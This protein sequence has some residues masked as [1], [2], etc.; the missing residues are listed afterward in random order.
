MSSPPDR[1]RWWVLLA[2]TGS[3]S[4]IMID[5]TIITVALP[6]IH[7]DLGIGQGMLEWVVI[8]YILVLASMMALG[9]HV[10]DIIGKPKAFVIG[11][12]AFGV[13]SLLCGM[14]WDGRSL[15]FFR[16]LQGL[17]AV[18]MQPASSALVIGSFAPGERGKAMG[19]YAGISLL[20]LTIGPV[21]GGVITEFASWRYCFYINLPVSLLVAAGALITKPTDTRNPKSG[22]DW[23]GALLLVVG[24]PAF[25]LGLKQGNTWGWDA[26]LTLGLLAGGIVLIIAFIKVELRSSHPVV[27]LGLF[28]DR[29]FMGDALMLMLTQSAVTGVMIF[30]GI[31]LQLVLGFTPVMAGFALMPLMLPVL[32]VMYPAGRTYDRR[33]ARTPAT[34]G[35]IGVT[36]GLATLAIGTGGETYWV[37][38]CGMAIIGFGLPF[39]Q[40]PSNTDG[41]SRVEAA[42]RGMASGVLQTFRQFGSVVGL[43]LIAA[44]IATT[45]ATNIDRL[46]AE[47][48]GWTGSNRTLVVEAMSGD[49]DARKTILDAHP[50]IEA[51]LRKITGS[52]ITWGVWTATLIAMMIVFIAPITLSRKSGRQT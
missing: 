32:A 45:Q 34:L 10:G 40:V 6:A 19:I 11:A 39:I 28:R 30:V 52:G 35:G 36:A 4:M 16:V 9:G 5:T 17:A 37:M 46:S 22:F 27:Q 8:A 47:D 26:P 23:P 50:E 33:G 49:A 13:C 7:E 18:L 51:E 31:Y 15:V 12:L 41:M 2:M 25:I 44:V 21:V 3:L 24:L 48:P 29:A 42:K 20:F 1:R 38:A 43:T 14:A